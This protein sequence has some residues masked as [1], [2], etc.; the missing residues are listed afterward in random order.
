MKIIRHINYSVY[1]SLPLLFKLL[2]GISIYIL[3]FQY[4]GMDVELPTPPSPPIWVEKSLPEDWPERGIDAHENGG[5]VLEWEPNIEDIII[6]A[7]IYRASGNDIIDSIGNFDLIERVEYESMANHVYIDDY[8]IPGRKYY[9]K[10]KVEDE[11]NNLSV[12]SDTISYFLL[13]KPKIEWMD[14][15]GFNSYLDQDRDLSWRYGYAL[16]LENYRLTLVTSENELL[17]RIIIFPGNYLGYNEYWQIPQSIILEDGIIYKWRIE[18]A[19]K[20]VDG[21]ETKGSESSW[22][23]FRYSGG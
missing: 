21:K 4:C 9:Y 18:T 5:I 23:T 11:S 10:M 3:F 12:S 19:A 6:A 2:Y 16:E 22:A 17:G 15:N 7:Y 14:P 1:E 20:Y 8:A 13:P